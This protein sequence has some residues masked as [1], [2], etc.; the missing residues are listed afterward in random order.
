MK[1]VASKNGLS[2]SL[3]VA[4]PFSRL[5]LIKGTNTVVT[6]AAWH[7][8]CGLTRGWPEEVVVLWRFVSRVA[9]ARQEFAMWRS[10]GSDILPLKYDKPKGGTMLLGGITV[11]GHS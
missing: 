11:L 2:L 6:M 3:T 10:N 4:M 1:P 8:S 5:D 7:K 9:E